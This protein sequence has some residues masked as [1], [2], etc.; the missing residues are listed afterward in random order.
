MKTSNPRR[1]RPSTPTHHGQA[2]ARRRQPVRLTQSAKTPNSNLPY[3]AACLAYRQQTAAYAERCWSSLPNSLRQL[4]KARRLS[5]YVVALR[6]GI[7]RDMLWRV[8]TGRSIPTFFI[9]SK[10]VFSLGLTWSRFARVL[11]KMVDG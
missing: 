1:C 9:L 8:E 11:D 7:S 10:I 4:R 2:Q 3:S 5:Q 6:A